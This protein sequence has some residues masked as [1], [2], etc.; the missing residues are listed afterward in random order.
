MEAEAATRVAAVGGVGEH[1]WVLG[2]HDERL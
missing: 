2:R 1:G